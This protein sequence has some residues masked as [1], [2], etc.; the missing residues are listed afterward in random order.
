MRN[1]STGRKP[2]ILPVIA[3]EPTSF[4]ASQ[5]GETNAV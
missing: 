5:L 3:A 4:A 1:S 2:A